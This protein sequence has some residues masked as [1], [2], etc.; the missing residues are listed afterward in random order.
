VSQVA[1]ACRVSVPAVSRMLNHLEA[2]GLIERRVDAASRRIVRVVLTEAGRDAEAEMVHR[3]V[4]SLE[5]VLSPL[6]SEEL[7]DLITAFGHLEQLL[8]PIESTPQTGTM[9]PVK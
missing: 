1:E 9:E 6:T 8:I 3:F 4:T 5:R 2:K 7:A